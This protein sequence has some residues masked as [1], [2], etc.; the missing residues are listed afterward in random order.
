[1]LTSSCPICGA[2][3]VP[4]TIFSPSPLLRCR[5]C[6]FAFLPGA[7]NGRLYDHEF[8]AN[9]NGHD[10]RAAERARRFESRRR[11]NLLGRHLP[12]P[13]RLLEVGGAAGFFLDEAR[14]RGYGG[15]GVE[16]NGEMAE[17]A[18]EALR[19]DVSAG[20]IEEVELGEQA[21][22]GACAFHVLEHVPTPAEAVAA[23]R[24]ALRPGGILLIEVPN[25]DSE[26]ARRE[27][28][29]WHAL[30]LP[31][32]VG[33]FGPRSMAALLE[34]AAL[35][36]VAIDSVPFAHYAAPGT[37]GL[38]VRGAM[39]LREVVR[40]RGAVPPWRDAGRHQLLRAVARRPT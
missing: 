36:V 25:A 38:P 19:L 13:A 11:L 6:D 31:Y 33:H 28:D 35:E 15:A 20:R 7:H 32:H 17:Y 3:S 26:V 5:D 23:V 22:D 4:D 21:F 27:G 29:H 37:L 12:P 34:G 14:R 10:Y 1:V 2:E 40:A 39:A 30:K 24:A 9:Y 16:L 8:F 18:R